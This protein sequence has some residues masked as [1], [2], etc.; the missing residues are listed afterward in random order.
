[1]FPKFC[2][3]TSDKMV[4]LNI[5][6]ML[7]YLNHI[8]VTSLWFKSLHDKICICYSVLWI[9]LPA[10]CALLFSLFL[11][12]FI[13]GWAS[14]FVTFIHWQTTVTLHWRHIERD[15]FTHHQRLDLLLNRMFSRRSKKTS[16]LRAS[17]LCEENSPM[18]GELLAQRASNAERVSIWW[19]YHEHDPMLT[20][21]D[22]ECLIWTFVIA[23]LIA[24]ILGEE[25]KSCLLQWF[26]PNAASLHNVTKSDRWDGREL[27]R[28]LKKHLTTLFN[29]VVIYSP[30]K[31]EKYI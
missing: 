26:V 9:F 5:S 1:M 24:H 18:T 15:G 8:L 14:Y 31:C 27:E 17:G 12:W 6:R 19:R 29:T 4:W 7:Q 23:T 22:R 25:P 16:K 11:N 21:P 28:Q 3:N 13:Y 30:R 20:S 2:R 10:L